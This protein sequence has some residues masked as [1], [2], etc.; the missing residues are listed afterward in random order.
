MKP[1][2]I[3]VAWPKVPFM[4]GGTEYLVNSL[5]N[6][7]KGKEWDIDTIELPFLYHSHESIMFSAMSWRLLDIEQVENKKVNLVIATK[8][9][10]YYIFHPNKVVWLIHQ[11]RQIY[12]LFG[13][14]PGF[15]RP[16]SDDYQLTRWIVD[17]DREYLQEAKA[18][19]AISRN[20]CK[21]LK[22]Y[23]GLEAEVLYPPPPHTGKY[24]NQDYE[25]AF[26]VVQRLEAN[27]RTELI[28][29]SLP[30]VRG[31]FN[32]WIAGTGPEKEKLFKKAR[33]LHL[34]RIVRFLGHVPIETLLE[35]YSRCRAV[36]YVPRDE[37]YGIVPLEAFASQKPIIT[38]NDSGGPLEFVRHQ[39][40]GLVTEPHPESLAQALQNLLDDRELAQRM[41]ETGFETIKNITW[42]SVISKLVTTSEGILE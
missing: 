12:D 3:L 14:G 26:L 4:R 15:D 37:D 35:L 33:S 38:T 20:V 40:N 24:R 6:Q 30:R 1:L 18:L 19:F 7:L 41:G 39:E 13:K 16:R 23:T 11:F 8:F 5:V 36:I 28:L 42:V 21:R 34:D 29:E 2:N 31:K 27:K 25:N 10:S 32:V 22:E 17:R 9:P